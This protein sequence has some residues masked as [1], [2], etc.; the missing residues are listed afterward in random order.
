MSEGQ[1]ENFWPGAKKMI[2]KLMK[3]Q[4]LAY[5]LRTRALWNEACAPNPFKVCLCPPRGLE[6][7]S[8]KDEDQ[9]LQT[10]WRTSCLFYDTFPRKCRFQEFFKTGARQVETAPGGG[11]YDLLGMIEWCHRALILKAAWAQLFVLKGVDSF[12]FRVAKIINNW[13]SLLDL[14]FWKNYFIK[15]IRRKIRALR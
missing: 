8:F 10:M 14:W 2:Q 11:F 15:M 13:K 5:P 9:Y 7:K 12:W 6:P 1:V 3:A 4:N